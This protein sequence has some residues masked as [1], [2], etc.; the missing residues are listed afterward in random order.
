MSPATVWK[1]RPV[2]ISSTFKDMQAERDHL[3]NVVFPELAERLRERRHHLEPID[4]RLGVETVQVADEEAK[5]LQ[6]L[7]VCLDEIERSRPF[8][9]VLLGDRYGWVPPEA[10]MQ[11]AAREAGFESPVAGKSVTALEIDFGLLKK[12]ADQRRRSFF[13][14]RDPLPYERMPPEVAARYSDLCSADPAVRADHDKLLRLKRRIEDD[15]E[16]TP[17]VRRY[18]PEWDAK[19]NEV[20]GLSAWGRRVLD[21][22]WGELDGETAEFAAQAEPTWEQ[23]E[24]DALA[25]FVELRGRDFIGRRQL[26]AD[27]LAFARSPQAEGADWGLCLTGEPGAGKSALFAHL[28][29]QLQGAP[30]ILLLAHAAGISLRA[31]QVDS[32]LRRWIQELGGFLQITPSLAANATAEDIE[33]TF[34]ELLGRA[35]T[36]RRVVM[37]IDAVNQFDSSTRAQYLTW[38]P[39]LLPPNARLIAT[40]VPGTASEALARRSGAR[41]RPLEPLSLD[42]SR[43]IAVAICR[44]RYHHEFNA[45]IYDAVLARRLPD[46]SPAAGNPLWLWLAMEELNLLDADDFQR[47]DRDYSGLPPDARLHQLVLDTAAALPADVESLYGWML[48]RSERVF[49]EHWAKAFA[50]LIA[51][52]RA[53]WRESDL[54]VLVPQ[55]TRLLC[56]DTPS[57]EIDDLL[58]ASLRRGFRAHLV[59]RGV[60]DQWDFFHLQMRQAVRQRNVQDAG[61]ARQ[62]HAAAAD[63]LE[64]LPA[65]DPLRVSEIMF[66]YIGADDRRRAAGHYADVPEGSLAQPAATQALADH[67]RTG[68]EGLAWV[69]SLV[70]EEHLGPEQIAAVA[71]A[72]NFDLHD[73]LVNEGRWSERRTLLLGAAGAYELLAEHDGVPANTALRGRSVSLNKMGDLSRQEGDPARAR[74]YYQQCLEILERLA[75]ALPNDVNAQRDLVVSHYKL[76]QLEQDDDPGSAVAH[77]RTCYEVLGRMQAAGMFLDPPLVELLI[78]L[79]QIQSPKGCSFAEIGDRP[80]DVGDEN[81]QFTVYRPKAIQSEKWYPMLVFA[82]LSEKPLEAPQSEPDPLEEVQR[83]AK[84]VLGDR[85]AEYQDVIQDSRQA[86]PHEGELTF[87]PQMPGIEFNPPRRS[88]LWLESVHRE[89]FRLRASPEMDGH[90]ARGQLSVFLGPILLAEVTLSI[91]VESKLE[92]ETDTRTSAVDRARPYRRIFASYS[93]RDG[94]IVDQFKRF[95]E[96][97]GDRYLRDCVDLRA[98]ELWDSRLQE[99]IEAADVFQLFWSSHSMRSHFVRQEWEHALS[100]RRPNFV[101]PTYWE[102]PL[103]ASP[104]ENLPPEVLRGLH[105][106]RIWITRQATDIDTRELL[107][108]NDTQAYMTIRQTEDGAS[109][110]V[111]ASPKEA[112][113]IEPASPPTIPGYTIIR[114]IAR[115]GMGTVCEAI[116]QH[117][118]Q[119]VAIKIVPILPGEDL[120]LRLQREAQLMGRLNHPNIVALYDSG[121]IDDRWCFFVMDYVCGQALDDDVRARSLS[122]RSILALFRDVCDAVAYAHRQGVIHCDLKPSNILVDDCGAIHIVD[123]GLARTLEQ[124]GGHVGSVIGTL[125][126]MSPEQSRGDP[127]LIDARTDVYSLGVILYELL[128]ASSP[129]PT[130]IDPMTA[131]RNIRELAPQKPSKARDNI[132]FDLDAIVLKALAKECERRY[133]SAGELARDIQQYLS[134]EP[135]HAMRDGS[136]Y[137]LRKWHFRHVLPMLGV[138]VLLTIVILLIIGLFVLS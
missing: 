92:A 138:A 43:A 74:G 67:I 79:K 19:N 5:E 137:S 64:K 37:L 30:D 85:A 39:P 75:R 102:D 54:R 90:I 96:T 11:A 76:A 121:I 49:G 18:R 98:G 56:P 23:L 46:G 118:G 78:S 84:Q 7:K 38:L 135:I 53:G 6:V 68:A 65:E 62:I 31:G 10:R 35:S 16:L 77:W 100:L 136:L 59:R 134:G 81:V 2:F 97:L 32:M 108:D 34:A 93:H 12:D 57:G 103:P 61:L 58:L 42:E 120:R 130:N 126:Y 9:I 109:T 66:H 129:Y 52:S 124:G 1:S 3:K 107:P 112:G 36:Q 89:E 127:S 41:L 63:H 51:L 111:P 40:A 15:P 95:V 122:V 26:T 133:Q 83:Q 91:R 115:G 72:F 14:F 125:R 106:Q 48:R 101:R 114:P 94:W 70:S 87:V 71:D 20:T 55:V 45:D 28:H 44:Q 22:L 128:T 50:A 123:F 27:L 117:S 99:M 69:C 4:L 21:D 73:A 80:V 119:K 132:D 105:F 113:C 116:Q 47:V 8:L 24:R 104:S 29:R 33:K 82:H 25:E 110:L 131:L 88:F 86:V 17:R 13:Y 60:Q